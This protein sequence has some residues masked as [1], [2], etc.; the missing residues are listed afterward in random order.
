MLQI[1]PASLLF[2]L[3]SRQA[4]AAWAK[5][6]DLYTPLL[7]HWAK[8][9]GCRDSD[10]ADLVQDV[11]LILW[12]KLPEFEY[13]RGQ[14][15]HSWLKTVF[16]NRYRTRLV[17]TDTT[18]PMDECR[19]QP[20][21]KEVNVAA[22]IAEEEEHQFLIRRAFRLIECEFS[23]LQQQM[24]RQ[25]VLEEQQPELVAQRFSVSVGT[26]YA[27]KSKVIS[28]LRQELLQVLE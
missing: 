5:F 8:S 1:T 23:Q 19:L 2:Q 14:S 20:E 25:Y 21:S 7:F 28:R 26:V 6:V 17:Q 11:F 22:R 27:V 24:F 16:M 3:R 12:R 4:F 15:F 10:K 13:D 9:S 18:V